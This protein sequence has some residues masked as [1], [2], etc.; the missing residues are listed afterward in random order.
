MKY[1]TAGSL[2]ES[3]DSINLINKPTWNFIDK[4]EKYI[5]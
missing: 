2:K 3:G 5:T 1:N 4:G